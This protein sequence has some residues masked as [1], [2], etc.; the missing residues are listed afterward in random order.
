MKFLLILTCFGVARAQNSELGRV[1]RNGDQ[2][3]LIVEG[4][5]PVDSA[6]STLAREFGIRVNVEDPAYIFRDDVKDVTATV[7]A[8]A[9]ISRPVLIPKGGNLELR[10]A[11]GSG[12]MPADVEALLRSLVDAAN[13]HF[14]FQYR[15]DA[16]GNWFSIVPTHTRD[17]LGNSVATLPLLDRHVTI[18]P[19]IRP[20]MESA[21]LMAD[22]LS[23]QTG[24]RVSCCQAAVAGIPWGLA[25]VFFEAKDEPARSVLKRLFTA[26][27]TNQPDRDYWLQRCDP[28]PSTGCF[29]NLAHI[30]RETV[31]SATN[32]QTVP[33]P[34]KA[35]PSPFFIRTP[36]G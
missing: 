16:D 7:S 27:A 3:A 10:F 20:I 25:A 9:Q 35:Q 8:D 2:A 34:V 36:A 21:S 24:L 12:G 28:L 14:P 1:E 30:S 17:Q 23:A 33:R 29:I 13:A 15:L 18:T 5:R 31:V 19:G 4:P 22:A 26:A 11:L 32:Q 6:A